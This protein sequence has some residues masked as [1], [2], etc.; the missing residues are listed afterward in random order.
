M[1]VYLHMYTYTQTETKRGRREN[2]LQ[3]YKHTFLGW[4]QVWQPSR[5]SLPSVGKSGVSYHM[6][7]FYI[8]N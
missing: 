7:L 1:H 4:P 5:L 6:Q 3:L 8:V 2:E